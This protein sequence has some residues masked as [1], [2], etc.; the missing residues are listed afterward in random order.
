VEGTKKNEV[1]VVKTIHDCIDLRSR[2]VDVPGVAEG[3]T[4]L[5]PPSGLWERVPTAYLRSI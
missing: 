2:L 3:D 4:G 1:I 5:E